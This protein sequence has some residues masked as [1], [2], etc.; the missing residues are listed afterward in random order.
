MGFFCPPEENSGAKM[1][2]KKQD[3]KI[4]AIFGAGRSGTSWLG[5]IV[6]SHLR[7]TCQN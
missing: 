3:C 5:S 4:G 6:S 2:T 1:D 7:K